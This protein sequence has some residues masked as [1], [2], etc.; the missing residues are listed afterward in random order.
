MVAISV[1]PFLEVIRCAKAILRKK[2]YV[3]SISVIGRHHQSDKLTAHDCLNLK[4]SLVFVL[5][6]G[7]Q[8]LARQP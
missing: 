7:Y 6:D 3:H 4:F 8:N 5:Y 2:I 1:K